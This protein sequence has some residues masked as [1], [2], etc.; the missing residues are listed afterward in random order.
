[1]GYLPKRL[2]NSNLSTFGGEYIDSQGNLYEGPYHE[3]FSGEAYSGT[4]P[5]S[6]NKKPL[7]PN[8]NL[9]PKSSQQIS[10]IIGNQYNSL[11]PVNQDL[12]KFG[13]DPESYYPT[14]TGQDYKRGTITR[15][16]AKRRNAQPLEIREITQTAFNSISTQDG[17]YN[18]AI[19]EVISLFWKISGPIRDSK[20]QYGVLK[21]G[22]R[23]TNER[24]REQ[25]NQQIR[26]I[27]GYLSD[28]IQF[29]VKADLDLV[30]GKYTAGGEF[31]VQLDNSDYSGYYHI[32]ADGTIMDGAEHGQSTGKILLAGNVLVQNQINT[33]VKNALEQVGSTP[34]Q[35]T[36]QQPQESVDP[37]PQVSTFTSPTT[38]GGY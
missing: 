26:G 34:S 14:P 19:W 21:S 6:P 12:Y 20:D 24:L 25:A 7:F 29:A 5:N 15:Y 11:N 36:Q 37:S 9:Q 13:A 23:D 1:M 10:S 16:F 30:N 2:V 33:L 3:L 8:S 4:T 31:T 17:Q 38:S 35:P 32:M 28:L 18:Y 27:K 22:I